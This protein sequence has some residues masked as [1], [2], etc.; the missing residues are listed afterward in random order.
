MEW[1]AVVLVL[2]K[3]SPASMLP[4]A[5]ASWAPFSPASK[6]SMLPITVRMA[7]RASARD[8]QLLP[9]AQ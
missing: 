7:S 1:Q 3:A 2:L 5:I 4:R 6:S 9:L 8:T